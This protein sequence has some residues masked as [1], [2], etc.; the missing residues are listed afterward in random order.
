ANSDQMSINKSPTDLGAIIANVLDSQSAVLKHP[1]QQVNF[2]KPKDPVVMSADPDKI[3]MAIENVV[4][5]AIKYSPEHTAI[6]LTLSRTPTVFTARG[7]GT[8]PGDMHKLFQTLSRLDN[9][10][11]TQAQGSGLGLYL[12][13]KIIELHQGDVE[14]RSAVGQGTTISLALPIGEPVA[15]K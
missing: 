14:V 3:R 4:S 12:V 10:R 5:N 7:L 11:T 2:N 9:P 8:A 15:S 1:D 6:N 13:K